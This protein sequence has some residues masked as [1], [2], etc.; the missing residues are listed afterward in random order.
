MDEKRKK[1]G[2]CGIILQASDSS[3][4][5]FTYQQLISKLAIAAIPQLAVLVWVGPVLF[6]V[7]TLP[8][9]T[10]A[11]WFEAA[12]FGLPVIGLA[13][14]IPPFWLAVFFAFWYTLA[15]FV[16]LMTWSPEVLLSANAAVNAFVAIS[17][18]MA[19]MPIT[20]AVVFVVDIIVV[21]TE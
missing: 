18:P 10:F 20:R 19:N 16:C 13:N 4:C 6:P 1:R 15:L 2:A 17:P 11:T 7:L 5:T 14:E 9:A 3:R 12:V 8:C 21:L